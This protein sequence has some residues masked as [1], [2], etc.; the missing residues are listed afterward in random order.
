[1][2]V[3]S[4]GNHQQE[5]LERERSGRHPAIVGARNAL[6][7]KRLRH[8]PFFVQ[9]GLRNPRPEALNRSL[10]QNRTVILRNAMVAI[11]P[12][13]PKADAT[14]VPKRRRMNRRANRTRLPKAYLAVLIAAATPASL[15]P[16]NG[17]RETRL[18]GSPPHCLP[19]HPAVG[20]ESASTSS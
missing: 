12:T 6:A 15:S 18:S 14:E 2:P 5:Q 9:D 1:M 3:H 16:A 17:T 4:A 8:D 19:C 10:V 13:S 20:S 11:R 7:R